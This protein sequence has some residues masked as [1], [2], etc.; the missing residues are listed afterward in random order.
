MND[1]KNILIVDDNQINLQVVSSYLKVGDYNLHIALNGNNA[2]K[3]TEDTDIDLVLMDI[4]MPGLDGF[5]TA[6]L[7]HDNEKNKDIPIIFLT[8]KSQT[9]DII[10][11]F[12]SGGVDYITK[13]FNGEEL[14]IRVKNHIDLADAKK[15]IIKFQQTRDR[16]YSV[17][18]HDIR[19]P[20][21]SM[22]LLLD[23]ITEKYID[24]SSPH[25]EKLISEINLN[26][27]R[28][29]SLIQNIL[30]WTKIQSSSIILDPEEVNISE[31]IDESLSIL[32]LNIQE[33]KI[34]VFKNIDQNLTL[35]VDEMTFS[36]IIRNIIS[37]GVKFTPMNGKIYIDITE[38]EKYHVISIKDTGVGMSPETIEKIFIKD[39]HYTSKGT[40]N[41]KG[42]GLGL[43]MVK[44]FIKL[45]KG[46]LEV[47]SE[48]SKGSVFH[49][50]F[51][52]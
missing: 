44:D 15:T 3:I 18:A 50:Y 39:E 7:I 21:A 10:Q 45:N 47:E 31:I 9:K 25:F 13:P 40:N 46:K 17:L 20:L 42:T 34:E 49:L 51:P 22:A 27:K 14:L 26:T 37:N 16:L 23:G 43:Y 4:M 19:S 48:L 41:E 24:Y 28:T 36:N 33:K 1:K 8:A 6:Q 2:I 30:D 12:K 11:G 35:C 52:R 32:N 38:T 5:Q 29:L